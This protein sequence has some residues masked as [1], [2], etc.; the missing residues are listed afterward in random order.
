[1]PTVLANNLIWL[2][3]GAAI[4]LAL[5]AGCIV[6]ASAIGLIVA[7]GRFFGDWRVRLPALAY[8]YWIRGTPLLILVIGVYYVLPYAGIELDAVTGGV[9]V[10]SLYHGAFM[11]EVFRGALM[12][13]P[14]GQW[15]AG[16]A[17]G[18]RGFRLLTLVVMPQALR[19]AGPPFVNTCVMLVKSTSIVSVI[20][21]WELTLAGR[22][23]VER[24][25][26]PFQIFGGVAAIY[27]LICYGLTLLGRT[28]E[29][30]TPPADAMTPHAWG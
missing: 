17:L 19:V 23:V 15:D 3:Y 12:S 21:L 9:I 24:T 4:T 6:L 29:T 10:L 13:V 8:L 30:R 22:Q 28:L 26:A 1:M 27:F 2:L 16:R 7:L 11:S 14:R 18:L 20:G 5:S 25:Q